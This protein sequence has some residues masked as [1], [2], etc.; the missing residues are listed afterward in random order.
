MIINYLK[1]ELK[2]QLIDMKP[3]LI[4]DMSLGTLANKIG[5]NNKFF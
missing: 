3:I 4:Y 2:I 1:Q 5:E